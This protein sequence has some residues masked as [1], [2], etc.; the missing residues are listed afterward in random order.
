[1]II[2]IVSF[3]LIL[4]VYGLEAVARLD[5]ETVGSLPGGIQVYPVYVFRDVGFDMS[6]LTVVIEAKD[7]IGKQVVLQSNEV[8][9]GIGIH[10][11]A[12]DLSLVGV[13]RLISAVVVP[14]IWP[15]TNNIIRVF[16]NQICS[17]SQQN[18]P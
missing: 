12:H 8:I 16:K 9:A 5:A 18:V 6:F 4:V 11:V 15:A 2:L 17:A 10:V 14:E 1:M 13:A 7:P 3:H